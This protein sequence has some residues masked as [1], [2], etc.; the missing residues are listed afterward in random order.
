M[1]IFTMQLA[2][3]RGDAGA[4]TVLPQ[5]SFPSGKRGGYVFELTHASVVSVAVAD[6][7]DDCGRQGK[8]LGL[9]YE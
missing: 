7:V 9:E 1:R 2:R 5:L 4:A 6:L 8:C 3:V